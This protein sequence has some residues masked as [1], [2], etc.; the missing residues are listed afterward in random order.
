MYI[1]WKEKKLISLL[2]FIKKIFFSFTLHWFSWEWS[3]LEESRTLNERKSGNR[4]R[5]LSLFVTHTSPTS[6]SSSSL[7]PVLL[8]FYPPQRGFHC[9]TRAITQ[10]KRFAPKEKLWIP[11]GRVLDVGLKGSCARHGFGH[12]RV[13][14]VIALSP[15]PPRLSLF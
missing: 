15:P 13:R 14:V 10:R 1:Q 12:D 6:S 5:F 4:H 8:N 3:S 9:R 11:I 2:W 7:F